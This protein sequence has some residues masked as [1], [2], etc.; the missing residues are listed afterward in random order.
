MA[1]SP[2]R[3]EITRQSKVHH[4]VQVNLRVFAYELLHTRLGQPHNSFWNH[5]Q[6][7]LRILMLLSVMDP[8]LFIAGTILVNIATIR[9]TSL[10]GFVIPESLRRECLILFAR[11]LR[12]GGIAHKS[13]ERCFLMQLRRRM[14]TKTKK[15]SPS[16]IISS[17][18]E[19]SHSNRKATKLAFAGFQQLILDT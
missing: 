19:G 3:G 18:L 12:I 14:S 9:G 7:P 2:L 5:L 10:M 11:H 16:F 4:R 15:L 6:S 13:I 1:N 8:T 17:R